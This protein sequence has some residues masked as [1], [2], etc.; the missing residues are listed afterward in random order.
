MSNPGHDVHNTQADDVLSPT[1]QQEIA[2]LIEVLKRF[3]R[4]KI[5]IEADVGS[6]RWSKSIPTTARERFGTRQGD[7]LVGYRLHGPD[8]THGHIES[9]IKAH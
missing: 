6:N 4:T 8:D 3:H 5:A 7:K 9:F 2:Q 1:R